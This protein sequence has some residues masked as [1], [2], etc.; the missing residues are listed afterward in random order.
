MNDNKKPENNEIRVNLQEY[1]QPTAEE[2]RESIRRMADHMKETLESYFSPE[3]VEVHRQLKTIL[4][5]QP[6]LT[7]EEAKDLEEARSFLTAYENHIS[8][9]EIAPAAE[10]TD[11]LFRRKEALPEIHNYGLMNDKVNTELILGATP[12]GTIMQPNG[13]YKFIWR[14][15]ESDKKDNPI[16]VFVSMYCDQLTARQNSIIS[17]VGT[18]LYNWYLTHDRNEGVWVTPAELWRIMC[19]KK[20]GESPSKKQKEAFIED[21]EYLIDNRMEIDF[22]ELINSHMIDAN[23][24]NAERIAAGLM[25]DDIIHARS[26]KFI[27]T[28]GRVSEGYYLKEFPLLYIFNLLA[29]RIVLVKFDYIDIPNIGEDYVVEFRDYILRRITGYIKGKLT[30]KRILLDTI[31]KSTGI[32]PPEIRIAQQ[33]GQKESAYKAQV[34]KLQKADNEKIRIILST[35]KDRGF[36]KGFEDVKGKYGKIIGFDFTADREKKE[37]PGK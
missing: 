24:L 15:N 22:A 10:L 25:K 18:C 23:D 5:A 32:Q 27:T 14:V 11:L 20:N 37:L 31:Y 26:G 30:Q 36:I 2:L 29:D 4:E 17:A 12:A 9:K 1:R 6:E 3:A 13:Q 34:R 8:K 35:L 33:P 28:R 19:G 7:A 16:S 21:L